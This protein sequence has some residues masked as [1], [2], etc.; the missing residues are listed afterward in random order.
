MP[1]GR[2]VPC[3]SCARHVRSFETS[4]PFCAAALS[5]A[6]DSAP[7]ARR[8]GPRLGRAALFALGAGAT[9]LAACSSSQSI[10]GAPPADDAGDQD[11][12]QGRALYGGPPV[13]AASDAPV[14]VDAAY[15]GPPQDAADDAADGEGGAAPAYGAPP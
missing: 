5:P 12:E 14:L 11:A 8:A 9:A 15:G 3:P 2:L 10:Y 1:T 6:A 13:D 4:C 7:V